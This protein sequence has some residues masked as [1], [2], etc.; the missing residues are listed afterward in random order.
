MAFAKAMNVPVSDFV[1]LEGEDSDVRFL[2]KRIDA[3][4]AACN[5]EKC[6]ALGQLQDF[7]AV[8]D[9]SVSAESAEQ[10]HLQK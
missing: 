5:E 9:S 2:P 6:A 7:S 3:A 10:F 4:L 1:L 8:H